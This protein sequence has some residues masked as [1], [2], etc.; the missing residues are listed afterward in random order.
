[1]APLLQGNAFI[2]G[3]GSG[4]GKATAFAFAE[5]GIQKLAI[6]GRNQEKLNTTAKELTNKYPK[7]EVLTVAMDINKTEEVKAGFSKIKAAFGR[8]D[9]AINNS[10]DL[11]KITPTHQL[12]DE[13]WLGTIN[14]NLVGT[15]R[16]QKQ[17]ISLMLEQEDLGV[18]RGRGSI[19]N[20][21]SIYGSVSQPD[22]IPYTA[23]CASKHGI[24]GLTKV[25]AILYAP[26]NIRINVLSPGYI[27]TPFLDDQIRKAAIDLTPKKRLASSEEIAD[28]IVVMSSPMSSFTQ[29]SNWIVDGGYTAV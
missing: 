17:E 28:T 29:G 4:L 16:C 1:M 23:Y 9:I 2:S 15:H 14:T 19:I 27:D 8:L 22:V 3:A 11:G 24:I 20:I 25:D 26:K 6:A 18:R 13:E 5:H 7:L 21:A 12:P 10:G